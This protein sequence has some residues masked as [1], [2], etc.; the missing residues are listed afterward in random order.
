[1]RD[2]SS[3]ECFSSCFVYF[4]SYFY[5]LSSFCT[6]QRKIKRQSIDGGMICFLCEELHRRDVPGMAMFW[7][8]LWWEE[9]GRQRKNVN[10]ETKVIAS[11]IEKGWKLFPVEIESLWRH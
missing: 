2:M 4:L 8:Q 1:M 11:S 7:V 10:L 3:R 5:A 9:I 6:A